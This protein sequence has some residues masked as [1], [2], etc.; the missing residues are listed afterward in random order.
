[1]RRGHEIGTD[2]HQV[3]ALSSSTVGNTVTFSISGDST[4]TNSGWTSITIPKSTGGTVTL[5]RS[6]ATYT[7]LSTTGGL[8]LWTGQSTYTVASGTVTITI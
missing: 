4:V 8:W 2:D 3:D 1:M 6:A 5:N 7:N